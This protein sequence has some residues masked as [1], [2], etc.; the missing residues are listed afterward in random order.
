MKCRNCGGE[1]DAGDGFCG[2]CGVPLVDESSPSVSRS[3]PTVPV[4][5]GRALPGHAKAVR[6][7]ALSRDGRFSLSAGDDGHIRLCDVNSGRELRHL[8][9]DGLACSAEFSGDSR[10]ALLGWDGVL[11][12]W[13][14]DSWTEVRRIHTRCAAQAAFSKNGQRVIGA[15]DAGSC[16][17][18]WN[19]ADWTEIRTIELGDDCAILAVALSPDGNRAAVSLMELATLPPNREG[20]LRVFEISSGIEL[21]RLYGGSSFSH[22][23]LFSDEG[24]M[25]LSSSYSA[26][27]LDARTMELRRSFRAG[28]LPVGRVAFSAD[29]RWVLGSLSGESETGAL[30]EHVW[31]WE[32]ET[33]RE[34]ARLAGP[35]GEAVS[36]ATGGD[37]RHAIA[38]C[39]DGSV[40]FWTLPS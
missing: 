26:D 32:M 16:F 39:Q 34:W 9:H 19:A 4:V 40:L 11:C 6:C 3:S 37:G 15:D 1:L 10:F 17:V 33:G 28:T 31:I 38:G 8:F 5:V 27:L 36:L 29:N 14:I 21:F 12:L 7:V 35:G 22:H 2:D 30:R 13:D 23:T 18:V 24:S 25:L 20:E